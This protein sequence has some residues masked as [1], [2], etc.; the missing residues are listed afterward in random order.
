MEVR[1]SNVKR[2]SLYSK[3]HYLNGAI[4]KSA[5]CYELFL[6]GQN[7]GFLATLNFPHPIKSYN[8]VHRLVVTP[9]YQ[10]IGLGTLFLEQ[11]ANLQKKDFAITTSN[12]ALLH[13]LAKNKNWSLRFKGRVYPNKGKLAALNKTIST[14]RNIFTFVWNG[15]NAERR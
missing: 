14:K 10:G 9:D 3:Y 12:P 4:H 8:K 13:S 2:W 15:K 11:I 7:V 6:N 5:K 1:V